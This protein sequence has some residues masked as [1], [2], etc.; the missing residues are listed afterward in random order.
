MDEHICHHG[1][2]LQHRDVVECRSKS[3]NDP[4]SPSV[5]REED[6]SSEEELSEDWE[7]RRKFGA[8]ET[9]K[10]PEGIDIAQVS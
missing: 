6:D 5:D 8:A 2:T 10:Y 3:V 9:F 1:D 4:S 7:E